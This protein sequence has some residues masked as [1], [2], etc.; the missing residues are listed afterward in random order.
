MYEMEELKKLGV[1]PKAKFFIEYNPKT[2]QGGQTHSFVYY[3]DP[4]TG[5]TVWFENAWDTQKGV[6]EYS[7]EQEMIKDIKSKHKAEQT[8]DRK[9]YTKTQWAQFNP[10]DHEP[11]ESLQELVNKCLK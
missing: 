3:K 10:D 2:N 8:D 11:G 9:Q 7:N 6:H 1:D 4:D 5:K